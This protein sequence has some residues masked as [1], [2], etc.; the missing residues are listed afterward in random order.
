[1]DYAKHPEKDSINSPGGRRE[2]SS[3]A[4]NIRL[5]TTLTPAH[6][7]KKSTTATIWFKLLRIAPQDRPLVT[8]PSYPGEDVFYT[9]SIGKSLDFKVETEPVVPK[10]WQDFG[11]QRQHTT[12]NTKPNNPRQTSPSLPPS[13]TPSASRIPLPGRLPFPTRTNKYFPVNAQLPTKMTWLDVLSLAQSVLACEEESA[14]NQVHVR[15]VGEV[16]EDPAADADGHSL[17]VKSH[18]AE[19]EECVDDDAEEEDEDT[20]SVIRSSFSSF[21]IRDV[22]LSLHKEVSRIWSWREKWRGTRGGVGRTGILR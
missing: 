16:D 2:N 4:R 9:L 11:Y 20:G 13:T 5:P 8:P 18:V 3:Q 1:M 12:R 15:T 17:L 7:T 19:V 6:S 14:I 10:N 22:N 21:D